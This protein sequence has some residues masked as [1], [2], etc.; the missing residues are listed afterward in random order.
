MNEH[1]N[2]FKEAELKDIRKEA[3]KADR[4]FLPK[5][6]EDKSDYDKDEN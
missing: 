4:H 6:D 3:V 5:P 1:E 2:E